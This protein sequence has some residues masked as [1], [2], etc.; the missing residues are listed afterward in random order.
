MTRDKC[1]L[2]DVAREANV[3]VGT[4]SHYLNNPSIVR[5]ENRQRIKRVISRLGYTP[6]ASARSLASGKSK[7]VILFVLSEKKISPTTWL[8]Q[9]PMIQ[10]VHDRLSEQGYSLQMRIV[11]EEDYV[12][13]LEKIHNCVEG[14]MADGILLLSVWKLRDELI[15][16]LLE[17]RYPFVCLDNEGTQENAPYICFDNRALLMQLVD[18]VYEYGHRKIAYINVQSDQQD[19]YMRYTGFLEGMRKHNLKVD[20]KNVLHGD[21]SINSGRE[22]VLRA[23]DAGADFTAILCGNDNI[24][25]G[26]LKA[27]TEKGLRVPEDISLIGIDNSIAANA[28]TPRLQ[29]VQ[30]DMPR[31][32]E[33]GV[34]TLLDAM[35]TGVVTGQVLRLNYEIIPGATLCRAKGG[36]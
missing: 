28:C 1:T 6:N 24:A 27:I 4:V 18:L 20:E 29:T 25:V 35:V 17:W 33:L 3:S 36:S 26:A 19:M 7:N 13:F 16:Y 32:A 5:L 11:Y 12:P 10:T 31:L 15:D 34:Q 22:C 21:F 8:H 2:K 30:F 14:K 9:L 23:L